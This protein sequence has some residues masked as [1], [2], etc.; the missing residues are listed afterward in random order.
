[1]KLRDFVTDPA[2]SVHIFRNANTDALLL[3]HTAD[4]ILTC[5]TCPFTPRI[6]PARFGM[7]RTRCK[8]TAQLLLSSET[9]EVG[10]SN[11]DE[12]IRGTPSNLD[13]LVQ[14]LIREELG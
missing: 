4:H 2:H 9:D 5:F 6:K 3:D 10:T 7:L 13:K 11:L 8:W 14:I 12:L 1:M